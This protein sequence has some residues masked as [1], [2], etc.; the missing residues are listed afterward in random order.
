MT[1]SRRCLAVRFEFLLA[2]S[3]L[4][5]GLFVVAVVGCS[6]PESEVIVCA[7]GPASPEA[8][9]AVRNVLGGLQRK[10]LRAMWEFLPPSYQ[11]DVQELLQDIGK[12][13]DEKSW[14][15]FVATCRKAHLV[16]TQII[17]RQDESGEVANDSNRELVAKLRDI[18]QFLKVVC[19]SELSDVARLRHLDARRFLG[20]TGNQL[21]EVI[22]HG[23]L[24]DSG[25]GTDVFSQFGAVNV[26][27]LESIGD[28]AV[29]NVQWPGQEATQHKFVRVEKCWIPKT[30]TEAW[31]M[32]FPKVREQC[33][34]WA[35]DLRV[36][37]EPWHARLREID[38]LLD[39]LAAIKSLAET[40]Q[41]WQAGASRLVVA[42]FGITISESPKAEGIPVDSPPPVKPARVKRPD[43]EVLLPDEPQK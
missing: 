6:K 25:L 37:P 32:E 9:V 23:T 17:R 36:S 33:L 43:T 8:D 5:A 40:R 16:T 1:V 24:S 29:L 13:V 41:V 35:D 4:L 11:A 28:S 7:E 15:P 31:P 27:L 2:L 30:L 18:E 21:V 10:D 39:E 34:V 42:W 26:E 14:G 3:G 22:S 12:R 20:G 19:E 38:Q